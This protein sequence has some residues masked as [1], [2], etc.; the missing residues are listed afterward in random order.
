MRF[1]MKFCS[2]IIVYFLTLSVSSAY[3]S[4]DQK[5][6]RSILDRYGLK[7]V[8]VEEVS[9]SFNG[10]ITS[11]NLAHYKLNKIA[12]RI[13]RLKHLTELELG[14]NKITSIP[15]E[16]LA[17]KSLEFLHLQNNRIEKFSAKFT[18]LQNLVYLDLTG[19]RLKEVPQKLYHLEKLTWIKLK[20]NNIENLELSKSGNNSGRAQDDIHYSAREF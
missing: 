6:V 14:D 2:F 18:G 7:H 5:I 17:M 3:Q 4:L 13:S 19:N 1:T 16:I 9:E 15:K 12:K 8:N 11:L 10:R 20:K